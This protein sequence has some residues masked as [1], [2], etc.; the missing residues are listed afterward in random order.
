MTAA[1]RTLGLILLAGWATAALAA[2]GWD[3]DQGSPPV[4][5]TAA[6]RQ[7]DFSAGLIAA[8]P[9]ERLKAQSVKDPSGTTISVRKVRQGVGDALLWELRWEPGAPWGPGTWVAFRDGLGRVREVRII[10]LDGTDSTDHK[11][12]QAGSWVRL[13]PQ[14]QGRGCRLD[15]FLAGRLVTGGWAVSASLVDVLGSSDSWLWDATSAD[16]DWGGLMPQR[17]WED[18][19]VETLQTR[20]H[21]LL[22]KVPVAASTLWWPDPQSSPTGTSE[23]GAPWGSWTLI[24]GQDGVATRGLGP[25]GVTLWAATGV[26]RGWNGPFLSR[27]ALIAQRIALPGYS[28]AMVPDDLTADPAFA[29]D[30]IRNLG[31]A[32]N[33]LLFPSRPQTDESSDVTGL[34]FLDPVAGAGYA[35]D[36]FPA[37]MHL[38]AVTKPGQIYL[39][40]LSVQQS[41]DKGASSSV[42]FREPAV[43]LP[44]VGTDQRVRVA[45]YAGPRE[46][47]WEQWLAQ[48]P[49]GRKGVRPDHVALT[50]LPLP[51]Q[52]LLPVLPAR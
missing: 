50:A 34:P 17:R 20:M 8:T 14:T 16:L 2:Q 11:V 10:L 28:Q 40:S 42:V 26:I 18:E 39:A 23:T 29:M 30:W 21:K 3:G 27:E 36:D 43:L 35:V 12:G 31:L 33:T 13:V 6:A 5:P 24:P 22:S 41:G 45:V 46:L 48:V 15:F 7:S 1:V 9:V 37:L 47:T 25:W 49:K 51:P 38:L 4:P 52:V 32:V 44:W 19:K